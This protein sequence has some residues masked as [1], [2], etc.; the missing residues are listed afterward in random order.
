MNPINPQT[1]LVYTFFFTFP[2]KFLTGSYSTGSQASCTDCSAGNFCND[3]T[4][5]TETPCSSGEYSFARSSS[6]TPCPAGYE[7]PSTDGSQNAPCQPGYYSTGRVKLEQLRS[8]SLWPYIPFTPCPSLYIYALSLSFPLLPPLSL[9]ISLS[10]PLPYILS[11][12]LSVSLLLT[13]IFW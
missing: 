5:S 2:P 9:S 12:S 11:L 4:S 13:L 1:Y 10:L 7:C 8:N 6:C 3:P